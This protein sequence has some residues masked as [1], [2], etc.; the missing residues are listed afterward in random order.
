MRDRAASGR[1][2]L[3]WGVLAA[4]LAVL[5]V[6]WMLAGDGAAS[7]A[8]RAA[9]RDASDVAS[10]RP[11]AGA[12]GGPTR[13]PD[14]D[15]AAARDAASAPAAATPDSAPDG[16]PA[17][18]P[19]GETA[20]LSGRAVDRQGRPLRDALV[21]VMPDER[22]R[23]DLGFHWSSSDARLDELPRARTGDDGTF[24]VQT[25]LP[26]G[27]PAPWGVPQ[28][29]FPVI[30]VEAEGFAIR[31]HVCLGLLAGDYDVGDVV[32]E[33]GGTL[34]GR[35][36]DESGRPVA[37]ALLWPWHTAMLPIRVPLTEADSS[38]DIYGALACDV[39]DDAGR[40]TLGPFWPGVVKCEVRTE[41]H[42]LATL[43]QLEIEPGVTR[44]LGDVVLARGAT[45][46]GTVRD[47]EGAPVAGASVHAAQAWA[48]SRMPWEAE[49]RD[50]LHYGFERLDAA[51]RTSTDADGAFTLTGLDP[52]NHTVYVD[53]PGFE[54][55]CVRDVLPAERPV[56]PP[57]E[58]SLV[59][60][61]TLLV[62]VVDA[63][64]EPVVD[65]RLRA[66]RRT[67]PSGMLQDVDLDVLAGERARSAIH[68][69]PANA[70]FAD[71]P[72]SDDPPSDDP[73]ADDPPADDPP[74]D[75][76]S[77]GFFLVQRP[78]TWRTDLIV[79]APGFATEVFEAPGVAP[80][81]AVPMDLTLRPEATVSG[82]VLGTDGTP[83]AGATVVARLPELAG[84]E[85]QTVPRRIELPV[86]GETSAADGRYVLRGLG[87]GTWL[88]IA[89]AAGHAYVRR[90]LTLAP[91]ES[92]ENVELLLA[93][94]GTVHGVFYAAD[95]T[96]KPGVDVIAS[97]REDESGPDTFRHELT[98]RAGAF[99]F[100]DLPAGTW[101]LHRNPGVVVELPPGGVVRADI[102]E[103]ARPAVKGRVLVEGKGWPTAMVHVMARP[104]DRE[105]FGQRAG[106][107]M[108]GADG[109]YEVLLPGAGEYEV[110][111]QGFDPPLG[112]TPGRRVHVA[113][114]ETLHV[115][116]AFEGAALSGVVVDAAQGQ[117]VAGA[118][119]VLAESS[120]ESRMYF[121]NQAGAQYWPV[122]D[123]EGRF[124][125]PHLAPDAWRLTV[126]HEDYLRA[127]I[128]PLEMGD[129]AKDVRVELT[130]GAIVRGSV[131][132]PGGVPVDE[133]TRV[134]R[135]AD[136]AARPLDTES[137]SVGRFEFRGLEPGPTWF[138]V[139]EGWWSDGA[140]SRPVLAERYVDLAPG[141]VVELELVVTP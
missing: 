32:L 98:D 125:V 138:V 26:A 28:A 140:F 23:R 90:E 79:F 41:G 21:L 131:T 52:G 24:A 101:T 29:R 34:T 66:V 121:K 17:T 104:Q 45:L 61:A 139:T 59:R 110:F 25:V 42:P 4:V 62:S 111:A 84:K 75:A 49:I 103:G 43:E 118:L 10:A 97:R 87:P 68:A 109:A 72:S 73:P 51:V 27:G 114:G 6:T 116:L 76:P 128:E 74:A 88:L 78:G 71:D 57:L 13:I 123:E 55:L 20:T 134:F 35:V 63:T 132:L 1:H 96:P 22:A 108:T 15:A 102:R 85:F 2:V 16:A 106:G 40:F 130:R 93:P 14:D 69:A 124:S 112:R 117:P 33:P 133:G 19:A 107:A 18:M 137:T 46:H 44:D 70:P 39:S 30:V 141:E 64:G 122:T 99:T 56:G 92:R 58:L 135:Q 127:V 129:L 105:T 65:A 9:R 119:V 77:G 81:A 120:D 82:R 126:R 8:E 136:P 89:S 53:A 86:A 60:Q 31:T 48:D 80:P 113:D 115:N 83:L 50:E 5:A 36:V 11:A 67:G 47:A 7:R 3:A 94:A 91:A 38:G 95:G 12:P 37:G 54:L 100:P